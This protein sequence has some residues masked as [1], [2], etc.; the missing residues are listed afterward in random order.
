MSR[1][2]VAC[3]R[4]ARV[5]RYWAAGMLGRSRHWRRSAGAPSRASVRRMI[6]TVSH[7]VR[8]LRG[9]GEKMTASRHLM[10]NIPT[11][12]GVSSGFVVGTSE[13]IRPTGLAYLAMPLSGSVS[14]TPTLGCRR[15]SRRMPMTLKR[16][17]TRLSGSPMP[18]SS[19]PI[20]ARRVKV[21]SLA[22]AHATAWQRRSTSAWVAPSNSW[23]AVR[24]RETSSSTCAVSSGV[25]GRVPIQTNSAISPRVSGACRLGGPTIM[26]SGPKSGTCPIVNVAPTECQ[27]SDGDW[28][29]TRLGRGQYVPI[30]RTRSRYT[31]RKEAAMRTQGTAAQEQ[32]A[33]A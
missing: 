17:L 21:L 6:S 16:L 10:A 26:N 8:L 30:V 22:T 20:C 28:H 12:G 3:T 25:I 11:P 5:I 24:A 7:V 4:S 33:C 1:P 29:L 14:I 9:W 2:P 23:S 19:T 18:L 32:L 15:T 31:G 13:A 27:S